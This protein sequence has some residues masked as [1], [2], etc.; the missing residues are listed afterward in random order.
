MN[1]VARLAEVGTMTVSR[2][3][4]G[5][6]RVSKEA[7][8]RVRAAI[9]QLNYRPNELARALRGER[10][11]TIGLILPYLYDPF[12]AVSAH[13]VST[14]AQ[15]RGYSV[16]MTTSNEDP[17]TEYA[18]AIQ[19]LQRHVDGLILIPSSR[20]KSRINRALLGKTHVV[21]FDRPLDD[22]S[23][24]TVLVQNKFGSR[25]MVQ[26][27]IGHG[28][29]AITF[30]GLSRSI[31]TM[32]ARFN[33]YRQAMSA[34]GL[35][36]DACFQ[37]ATMPST[38]QAIQ[39][40]LASKKKPTAYFTANTLVTRYVFA[41]LL[42]LGIQIPS[43]VALA[44]FDDFELADFTGPPLTVVRQ[45]AEEMGRVAANQ[46]FDRLERGEMP[47]TGNRVVLPVEIVLRRSCGCKNKSAVIMH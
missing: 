46:L 43:E 11:R 15:Q 10:T 14:V 2:V 38:L 29:K 16:I 36:V 42:Q 37:C 47:Q 9:E 4:N 27:L 35:E 24:D 3:L 17:E 12:F 13:A 19:M 1:D 28:H 7:T 21:V 45:P 18:A 25:R 32:D 20:G 26:H 6:A 39:T 8:D 31:F 34:A 40:R 44:G 23:F 33:G 22:N 30:M 41:A 5:S